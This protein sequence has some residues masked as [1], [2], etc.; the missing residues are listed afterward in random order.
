MNEFARLDT[1]DVAY[2]PGSKRES[3]YDDTWIGPI[4]TKDGRT[5]V[6][7]TVHTDD[8]IDTWPITMQWQ[9]ILSTGRVEHD[10]EVPDT[11][12]EQFDLVA[13]DST[14]LEPDG[15]TGDES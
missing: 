1:G 7:V 14:H 2:C 15:H 11:V 12:A 8:S 10:P 6:A 9:L 4:D 5:M 3:G 13:G